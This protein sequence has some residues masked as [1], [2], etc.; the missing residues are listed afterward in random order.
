MP[1][2][3]AAIDRLIAD[4]APDLLLAPQAIGGH[5]DHVQ[6]VRA[7]DGLDRPILWW[8]DFPY[9][10]RPDVPRRPYA[11]RF[12]GLPQR[13]VALDARALAAREAACGAYRSQIGYQFG[14]SDALRAKL[15]QAGATETFSGLPTLDP[16]D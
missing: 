14:G 10:I 1:T 2:V 9:T 15:A 3:R 6:L 8:Q 13:R 4:E 12:A 16:S 7:L 5:V 11:E